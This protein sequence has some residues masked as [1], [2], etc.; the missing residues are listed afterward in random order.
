MLNEGFD[1]VSALAAQGWSLQNNST[2]VGVTGWFQ[3]NPIVFS[4]AGGAPD[5]YIAANYNN[6]VEGGL[7]SNWLLTPV[8]QLGADGLLSFAYRGPSEFPFFD[9][10]EIYASTRGDSTDVGNGAGTT[11]DFVLLASLTT[12]PL[13]TS[14]W[15]TQEV[16]LSVLGS[17]TGRLGFRYTGTDFHANYIGLD[18][19]VVTASQGTVPEPSSLALW[20]GGLLGLAAMRRRVSARDARFARP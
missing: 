18:N 9:L 10:L 14:A 19:V 13:P 3:G 20:A 15:R 17:F 8:L 6:T 5:A 4:A 12:E 11:G 16:D 2:P 1:D 7:I